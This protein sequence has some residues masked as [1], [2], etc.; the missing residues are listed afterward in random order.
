V[1]CQPKLWS[2][3]RAKVGVRSAYAEAT[4]DNLRVA[5]QPKLTRVLSSVSEG[6]RVA[7]EGGPER[8]P[9]REALRRAKRREVGNEKGPHRA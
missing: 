2:K 9:S 1:A 7:A 5:C 6:W 4:A 3:A 8:P